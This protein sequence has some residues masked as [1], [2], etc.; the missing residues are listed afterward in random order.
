MIID[1]HMHVNWNGWNAERIVGHMDAIGVD[2]AC[3][4]TWENVDGLSN[5]YIHLA[6][7]RVREACAAYPDRFLPWYA[8]D[9]RRLDAE[10]RLMDAVREGLVGF[11]EMKVQVHLEHPS[12]LKLFRICGDHGLPVLIHM[13]KPIPPDYGQWYCTD[14]DALG[15][16]CERFPKVSF[17]GHGPG[18]WRYVSGDEA[19]TTQAYPMGKVAPGGK[20]PKLLRKHK[21]LY[22]DLSA[23][24]GLRAISRDR[25]WGRRFVVRF[26]DRMV[27]GTDC[28]NRNH[29]DYLEGLNLDKPLLRRVLGGNLKRLLPKR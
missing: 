7:A 6:Y 8:P 26:A 25:A 28:Y 22:C 12:L 16:V 14:I 4:L 3:L 10:L 19:A 21:N 23:G 2:Q 15:A 9:P 29:L 17:I 1:C 20:L 13:D 18:F 27:Y 11:G 24:S 5:H